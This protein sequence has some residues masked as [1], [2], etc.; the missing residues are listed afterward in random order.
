MARFKQ[1]RTLLGVMTINLDQ[2][3]AFSSTDKTDSSEAKSTVMFAGNESRYY[4]AETLEEINTKLEE[5]CK[6]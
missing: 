2:V 6:S 4:L 5:S 3:A 1:F